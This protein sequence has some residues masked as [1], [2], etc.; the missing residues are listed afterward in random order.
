MSPK[1]AIDATDSK[2]E[3][4]NLAHYHAEISRFG[5]CCMPRSADEMDHYLSVYNRNKESIYNVWSQVDLNI[6]EELKSRC[7]DGDLFFIDKYLQ[8]FDCFMELTNRE[9]YEGMTESLFHNPLHYGMGL[10]NT[11]NEFIMSFNKRIAT[12]DSELTNES[13]IH[14]PYVVAKLDE[15]LTKHGVYEKWR[16]FTLLQFYKDFCLGQ[17]DFVH[18]DLY[19]RMLEGVVK[20]LQ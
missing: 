1:P 20:M 7:E 8:Y 4:K 19:K 5:T 17:G 2:P 16:S 11:L 15:S 10:G 9:K 6:E 18:S 13:G 14:F 12:A 3:P